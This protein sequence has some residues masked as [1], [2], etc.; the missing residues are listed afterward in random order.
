M[1][2]SSAPPTKGA[3]SP[4]YKPRTWMD[5]VKMLHHCNDIVLNAHSR[6]A[7]TPSNLTML[8]AQSHGPLY[9]P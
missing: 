4:L 6:L 1:P 9:V 2:V 3:A 5:I 8:F 7:R